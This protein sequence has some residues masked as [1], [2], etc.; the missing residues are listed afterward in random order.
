M[1]H[2]R[3]LQKT[4]CID[5]LQQERL[6]VRAIPMQRLLMLKFKMV[7]TNISPDKEVDGEV[8]TRT[9]AAEKD[10]KALVQAEERLPVLVQAK[11]KAEV[12]RRLSS[13]NNHLTWKC[14]ALIP[15]FSVAS[16]D[17]LRKIA[18]E[19]Q[20]VKVSKQVGVAHD[21]VVIG[22]AEDGATFLQ[23]GEEVAKKRRKLEQDLM[24]RKL[25]RQREKKE[26]KR[27]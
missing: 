2:S 23:E 10:L 9:L 17:M 27:K 6:L 20:K 15:V 25:R 16:T 7:E 19:I 18:T 22:N 26:K 24:P 5:K 3:E 8:A 21:L 14:K 13:N 1:Q 4:G 11:A 12:D